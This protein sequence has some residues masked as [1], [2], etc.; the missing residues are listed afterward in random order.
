MLAMP[1]FTQDDEE[2]NGGGGGKLDAGLQ[3]KLFENAWNNRQ[4]DDA[5]SQG[6]NFVIANPD[7]PS[8]PDVWWRSYLVYRDYRP[9]E[10]KRK[11][12]FEKAMIAL[13]KYE[14]KYADTKKDL[15]AVSLW[16]K[17]ELSGR[18]MGAQAGVNYLLDILKKYPGTPIEKHAAYRAGDWLRDLKRYR[19]AI[20]MYDQAQKL[21]GFS[22][23][24]ADIIVRRS[25]CFQGLNDKE[26]AIENYK[27]I[28]DKKY[29]IHWGSIHNNL[30]PVARWMKDNGETE[31]SRKF[32][33]RLVD[34]G[35]PGWGQTQEA[36]A[37][38]FGAQK[39][40][41][42]EPHYLLRYNTK[43]Q[44]MDGNTKISVVKE[45][46][47]RL[48]IYNY[49]K[50]EPFKGTITMQ[51]I[52]DMDQTTGTKSE[53]DKNEILFSSDVVMPNK[54]GKYNDLW[55]GFKSKEV[56]GTPPGGL[57]IT[58]KW[59]KTGDDWG[60]ATITVKSPYRVHIFITSNQKL[61]ANNFNDQ[62]NA[63]EDGDKTARWYDWT[64]LVNGRKITFPVTV[65]K[66]EEYY[67]KVRIYFGTGNWYYKAN[68]TK[69]KNC[70]ADMKEMKVTLSSEID[71]SARL[72]Y[73]SDTWLTMDEIIK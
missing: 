14:R 44:N 54:D 43:T 31:L 34:E 36:N 32:A 26:S 40:I 65:G 9:N 23:E 33:M 48:R 71:F 25:W 73:P 47:V 39:A 41:Y 20:E 28:L 11:S 22:H 27:L 21:W 12:T 70:V 35:N 3:F 50:E 30:M 2:D 17:G 68:N 29:S 63:M 8:S 42:V 72:E 51:P 49:P 7:H 18:E 19:E 60:M 45:M 66:A 53:N 38:L 55:Y 64:D 57:I 16:Y 59:E 56:L 6:I 61:N 37:F 13:E 1:G 58:R 52:V 5:A 15:A 4:F 69:G 67:P 62:P 10:P 24:G 46:P